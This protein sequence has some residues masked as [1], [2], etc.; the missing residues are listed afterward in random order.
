MRAEAFRER[1][2]PAAL[3]TGASSGI[4]E[5]LARG[6]AAR[7]LD[8]VLCARRQDR[9]ERLAGELR[10]GGRRVEVRAL[11]LAAPGAVDELATA[12]AGLDVGL[13]AANAGFGLK[14]Y[15]H[16][17]DATRLA[18][19]VAVNAVAPMQLCRALVP[20]LLERGRGGIMLTSSIEGFFGFPL[21]AAYSA[22]KA[23]TMALGQGLWGELHPLGIDV[24]VV[25]PGSTDTEAL[26]LQGVDTKTLVGVMTPASVAEAALD[27]LGSRPV[28]VIGGVNRVGV[29]ALRAL[30]LRLRLAAVGRGLRR[31]L[32]RSGNP[33]TTPV[34]DRTQG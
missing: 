13:V 18:D 21:S 20:S 15:H 6:L 10:A 26:P 12:C 7:G 27:A 31:T 4:G 25:A 30:P 3:V 24:L 22:T 9:L 17:Q 28:A 16:E 2:G 19:M 32:E 34:P 1:Y 8:L 11:D 14:G 5:H 23:F 29:A 33:A